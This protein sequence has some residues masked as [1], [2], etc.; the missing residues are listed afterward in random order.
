MPEN[1]VTVT[2]TFTEK[3]DPTDPEEGGSDIQL[4]RIY[5]DKVCAGVELEYSREVVKGGQSTI[6]T[7]NVEKG[8]DASALKLSYKE[9][10]FGDW[11]PLTLN[12][13]GQY[14]IKNIWNDIYVRAEGV[15]T[16]MEDIDGTA[17]VYAK[18]G[19]LYIYTPQQDDIAVISMTGSVVKRTK[20]IGLQSYPLNQ[21]IYVVRVGE[22]VFKVRVK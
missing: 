15:V 22:Q 18:D 21:G 10:M 2:A 14:Q 11:K 6:V 3:E 5:T 13:D 7:V 4:Y 8:Y 20:Q 19:S 17:R 1:D 9:G 12:K 16:G